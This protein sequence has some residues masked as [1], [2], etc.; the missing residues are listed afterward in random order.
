MK[1]FAKCSKC[2]HEIS[3]S[4]NHKTRVEFAM[5]EGKIKTLICDICGNKNSFKVND[6]FA[7]ESKLA[8]IIAGIVFLIGTPILIYYLPIFILKY[9]GL[10]TSLGAGGL[11]LIPGFIYSNILKEDRIRVNTF[12]RGWT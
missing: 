10:Y 8:F 6:I 9:G 5:Y 3:F 11:L 2:K 7:K 1:L 12:N 4:S